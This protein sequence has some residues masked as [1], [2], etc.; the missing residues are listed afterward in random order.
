MEMDT[1]NKHNTK[2]SLCIIRFLTLFSIVMMWTHAPRARIT[3]SVSHLFN[4]ALLPYKIPM[5]P[6]GSYSLALF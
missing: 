5:P 1:D 4:A 3:A 6:F 2:Y